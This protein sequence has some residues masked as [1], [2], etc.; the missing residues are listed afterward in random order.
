MAEHTKF[1]CPVCGNPNAGF[2]HCPIHEAAPD[3]LAA[4]EEIATFEEQEGDDGWALS[5]R[6][7]KA[8][9]LANAAIA[10][11]KGQ[12]PLDFSSYQGKVRK[13]KGND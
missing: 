2:L 13:A 5:D 12:E 8:V 6:L 11:A 3:L 10:K 9:R 4:L 1:D 7:D